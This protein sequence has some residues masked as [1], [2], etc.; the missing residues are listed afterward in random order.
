MEV[1]EKNNASIPSGPVD[2]LPFI[3]LRKCQSVWVGICGA[4][5]MSQSDDVYGFPVPILSVGI[6]ACSSDEAMWLSFVI[7]QRW[8]LL[9]ADLTMLQ[10]LQGSDSH[11][12]I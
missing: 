1:F 11:Q 3:P 10:N 8:Y 12:P 7:P 6:L 4:S 5:A 2:F 9:W